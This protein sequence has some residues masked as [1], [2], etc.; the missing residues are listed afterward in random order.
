M[1]YLRARVWIAAVALGLM[2]GA[3][4]GRSDL[5][6]SANTGDLHVLQHIVVI[7]Q[8]NRSFDSYFGT[9]P[10]AEGIPMSGGVPTVCV[11]DPQA[12]TCVPPSHDAADVNG[13]GPHGALAAIADID[14]GKMDG[15]IGRAES[16]QKG[17]LDPL[18][19]N[20]TSSA[21]PDVMGYHDERELP[22][23]WAYAQNFVLQDHLFEANAS[24]SLPAHLFMVSEWSALCFTPAD[25][26]SCTN[27]LE[28]PAGTRSGN[29]TYGRPDY[30]WTDLTYLLHG[31]GVSWAYYVADGTEPD[32]EDDEMTCHLNPQ[33][34]GTPNIWNPLP[35]FDT[36]LDDGELG[37]IRPLT[38]FYA[39][40]Q[41]GTLPAVAWIV[42]NGENSEHP[43]SRVSTGQAYV[44]RLIN[45]IM[46][47]PN[48]PSTAIFLSWDDWG[49]FYDH[50][51]PPHVDENGYGLRVPGLVIS[52]F[53][54]R[55]FIDH[56]TLS[57]DAYVKFIED[58]FL[59]GQRLDP[60]TDGRPDPRP[61]VREDVPQLGDLSQDFDFTQPPRAPLL[62]PPVPCVGDCNANHMVGVDEILTMVRISLGTAVVSACAAGDADGNGQITIDEILA[63]VNNA[64]NGCP[65][66]AAG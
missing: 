16:A 43:P 19:P 14:G 1:N 34:V 33:N 50:V 60:N 55:G 6:R 13:G 53:A 32:C 54:K 18:N 61:S 40:A 42:P 7:M 24:W 48:W 37:N 59:G 65:A 64:L 47:S 9:F 41:A 52:P 4:S 23:Y 36:V 25:P 15:F 46:Q 28:I 57:F 29:G 51:V 66:F 8:E 62:L 30:A 27:A 58:V 63:A 35:F 26:L 2:V 44:T 3:R 20:C 10:G 17:C 21:T 38:D 11:P 39:A 22:N 56:Q 5:R 31:A 12:G 49:G 45:A